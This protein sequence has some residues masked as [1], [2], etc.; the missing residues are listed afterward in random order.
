M[1]DIEAGYQSFSKLE[2]PCTILSPTEV[3]ELGTL[4]S[5]KAVQPEKSETGVDVKESGRV[6]YSRDVQPLKQDTP[7][8]S[9]SLLS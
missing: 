7:K 8:V 1:L 4:N 9:V 6:T 2:Q 3:T 5:F